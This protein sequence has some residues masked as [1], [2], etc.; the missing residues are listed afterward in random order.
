MRRK[1]YFNLPTRS[2]PS[3]TKQP[4]HTLSNPVHKHGK[5]LGKAM[6]ISPARRQTTRPPWSSGK[7]TWA[8][9]TAL[10]R[11]RIY[12][13]YM[14]LKGITD[15]WRLWEQSPANGQKR[16]RKILVFRSDNFP[17]IV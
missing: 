16:P 10:I 2:G 17:C 11:K 12:N 13:R 14:S 8:I 9:T 1:K 5:N 4:A 3:T 7:Y 6:G 15:L